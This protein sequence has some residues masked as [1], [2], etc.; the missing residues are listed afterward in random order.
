MKQYFDTFSPA[1]ITFFLVIIISGYNYFLLAWGLTYPLTY[2]RVVEVIIIITSTRVRNAPGECLWTNESIPLDR[3]KSM[4]PFPFSS[5]LKP[6]AQDTD[7]YSSP[8]SPSPSLRFQVQVPKVNHVN[9]STQHTSFRSLVA[10]Q[11]QNENWPT[12]LTS[13]RLV[14]H[15]IQRF[16]RQVSEVTTT[17]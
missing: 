7:L 14:M 16:N 12:K 11:C 10:F 1:D 5:C 3:P 4:F 9:V 8:Q 15:W 2:L 17:A 13:Y 6:P